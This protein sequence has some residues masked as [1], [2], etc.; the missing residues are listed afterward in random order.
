MTHWQSILWGGGGGVTNFCAPI[1][2]MGFC[3]LYYQTM[4]FT[5]EMVFISDGQ[6]MR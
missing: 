6:G 5:G 4:I 2:M 3:V 1:W